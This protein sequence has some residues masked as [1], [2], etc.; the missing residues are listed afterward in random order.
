MRTAY[1]TFHRS[2]SQKYE[3]K[4]PRLI[5]KLEISLHILGFMMLCVCVTVLCTV[6]LWRI[7][8]MIVLITATLAG[9][10]A[11]L[12]LP[13]ISNFY[14]I[15]F[16]LSMGLVTCQPTVSILHS[17]WSTGRCST[18]S[19]ILPCYTQG[20]S[21]LECYSKCLIALFQ[22]SP[23]WLHLI[24]LKKVL[25][26]LMWVSTLSMTQWQRKTKLVGD[27]DFEGDFLC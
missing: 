24:R 14:S 7:A 13:P 1:C 17:T 20:K 9:S 10:L 2:E 19:C 3:S 22:V 15:P 26:Q 18:I 16:Q 25:L 8:A 6:E 27:V 4:K 11:S 21:L 23:S 12:S 5:K